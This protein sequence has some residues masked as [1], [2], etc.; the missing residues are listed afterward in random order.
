MRWLS[1]P[2]KFAEMLRSIIDRVV[3]KKKNIRGIF[4]P[5]VNNQSWKIKKIINKNKKN[6]IVHFYSRLGISFDNIRVEC[7]HLTDEVEF[8]QHGNICKTFEEQKK[9]IVDWEYRYNYIRLH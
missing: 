3:V 4:L 2:I 6:K 7:S 9:R 1:L 8:Y 5:K